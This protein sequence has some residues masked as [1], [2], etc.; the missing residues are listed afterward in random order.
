MDINL[1]ER[2]LKSLEIHGECFKRVSDVQYIMRCPICGDTNKNK[3]HAHCYIKCNKF[4]TEPMLYNCFLCNSSGMVNKYFLSKLNIDKSLINELHDVRRNT[5]ITFKSREDIDFSKLIDLNSPQ[6]KYIEYRLGSG[7]SLEDYQKFRIVNNMDEIKPFI[8]SQKIKNTL[9][10]NNDSVSFLSDD[11]SVLLTRNF[12]D[13][14]DRWNKRRLYNTNNPSIYTIKTTIDLFTQD[15]IIINIS[16]GVIDAISIYKNFNENN[17]I[18]LAV[19][20][21]DYTLGLRYAISKGLVGYNIQIRIYID[22]NINIKDL[23]NVLKEYKWIFKSIHIYQNILY[24][25]VGTTI[26]KISLKEIKV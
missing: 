9:P 1:K 20:G 25:D 10:S 5:F 4:N 2:I 13:D 15:D 21:S 12:S 24:K 19:L 3:H 18:H 14:K 11:Y 17:S 8:S 7:L 6:I 26:D 23:K 16:E 22:D